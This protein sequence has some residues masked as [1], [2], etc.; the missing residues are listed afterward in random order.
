MQLTELAHQYLAQHL[1]EGALA[2][3]AT[4]G[5]GHDVLKMAQL[6]GTTG[7]VIAIDIQT[8]ALESTRERLE[9]AEVTTA[10][11]I[12]G[13]HAK[14]FDTLLND[15]LSQAAAITFNLGYL[16]GSDKSVQ[17]QPAS[18]LRALDTAIKLLAPKGALLVT[19]YRGHE[20][21]IEE[22]KQVEQ[23]M[24]DQESNG[25]IVEYH[26]P[27]ALRIPPILWVFKPA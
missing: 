23:W 16:P 21:G 7:S 19:A 6:V 27:Q 8:S 9:K 17:T 5:N 11:L 13:D 24:L 3:D 12:K 18:T 1:S 22:S 10:T 25:H 14:V 15:Y 26:E 4:A 20:G 2:I